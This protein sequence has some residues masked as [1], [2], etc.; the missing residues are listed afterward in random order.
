M[1]ALL[2]SIALLLDG[3]CALRLGVQPQHWNRPLMR[4]HRSGGGIR[5]GFEVET[6][7]AKARDEMG[8]MTWPG[9]QQES[10]TFSQRAGA[11]E[12]LMVYVKEGVGTV[13]DG[14]DTAQ[15]GEGSML[16]VND[17]EV[18]WSVPDGSVTL[19]SMTAPMAD[20]VDEEPAA[21]ASSPPEPSPPP[22]DLTILEG[23]KILA[24]G[25]LS[26]LVLAFGINMFNAAA[27]GS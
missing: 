18:N 2:A 13:T 24:A 6:I 7:D 10:G 27:P 23:A 8:V 19:L 22:Q 21:R 9:L 14:E 11:A 5:L 16:M 3:A 26:G 1:L 20:V 4:A 15:V 17:G 25:L 12:I